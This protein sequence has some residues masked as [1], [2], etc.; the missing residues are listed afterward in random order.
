MS[1]EQDNMPVTGYKSITIDQEHYS[2]FK[3]IADRKQISVSKL[4][5]WL[6]EQYSRPYIRAMI[7]EIAARKRS[8]E[9]AYQNFVLD[10]NM[11]HY[12][13]TA[14][15]RSED[16]IEK[17]DRPAFE[18]V[19][20]RVRRESD[21]NI[22]RIFILSRGSWDNKEVWKMIGE[23]LLFRFIREKQVKIFVLSEKVADKILSIKEK[24]TNQE[25][26]LFRYYD[27]GIYG[28][29]R[30]RPAFE[31]VVG[32]LEVN[33]QSKPGDYDRV[34]SHEDAQEIKTAER[35]FGELK[36]CAQTIEELKDIAK[37]QEQ[38]YDE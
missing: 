26:K 9:V 11:N 6:I 37:L 31:V 36:K 3:A 7:D 17:V 1:R 23:W 33:P 2:D 34:S 16:Y 28:R 32:Y 12:Q 13:S 15:V 35:Y 18:F 20:S 30:D 24:D 38:P 19:D 27:M 4:I 21:F 29:T 22:E 10:P 8:F 5:E 14:W 25:K